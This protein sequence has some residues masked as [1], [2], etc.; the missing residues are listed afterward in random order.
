PLG[1]PERV[2]VLPKVREHLASD[3]DDRGRALPGIADQGARSAAARLSSSASAAH[4]S[5]RPSSSAFFSAFFDA[6]SRDATGPS[7]SASSQRRVSRVSPSFSS[8]AILSSSAAIFFLR[9]AAS[10]CSGGS[11]RRE[12]FAGAGGGAER[13]SA[14]TA[15]PG[16]QGGSGRRLLSA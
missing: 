8:S 3:R 12:G 7:V 16:V 1:Q 4:C 15:A 6:R 11:G 9:R 5:T 14:A 2:G 13:T 10:F